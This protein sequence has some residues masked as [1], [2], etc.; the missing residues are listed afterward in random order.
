MVVK[1]TEGGKAM[2]PC[3]FSTYSQNENRVTS[4]FLAVLSSLSL[5]LMQQIIGAMIGDDVELISFTNQPSKRQQYH[6]YQMQRYLG[7][8]RY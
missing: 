6:Q 7:I 8:L 3:L 5:N 2:S 1:K 4:T